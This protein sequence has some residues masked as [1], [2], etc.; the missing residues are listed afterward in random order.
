M[1]KL[2]TLLLLSSLFAG[3]SYAQTS[4]S[5]DPTPE[6]KETQ[7]TQARMVEII[8]ELVEETEGPDNSLSFTYDGIAITM[9]SDVNANRMR[10]LAAVIDAEQLAEEQMLAT[11]VSNYHLALDAR[12]AIGGNVLYSTYIHPL[13][14]LTKEQLLS[15]VRQVANL[16][17]TFGSTYSSGEMSF[18]VQI[19]EE[20]L[21]I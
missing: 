3:F 19:Q 4:D 2:A 1:K 9:V 10:L 16:S 18:G 15:G 17:K 12:Y 20:R 7:M 14:P 8:R 11:L 6:F 13:S 5:P 21:D